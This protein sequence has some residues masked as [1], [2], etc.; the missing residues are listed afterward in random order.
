MPSVPGRSSRSASRS[1]A[2]AAKRIAAPSRAVD[3]R[4]TAAWWSTNPSCEYQKWPGSTHRI[5]AETAATARS[6]C[7]R[8]NWNSTPTV[9]APSAGG[10]QAATRSML[11]SS[12]LR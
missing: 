4:A 1:P 5:A 11:A 10:T 7:R 6:R 3:D 12:P 8:A 9:A 2:G